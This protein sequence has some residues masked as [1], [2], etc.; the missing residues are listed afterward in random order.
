MSNN[1]VRIKLKLI[2]DI[3]RNLK[4]NNEGKLNHDF[5]W[6]TICLLGEWSL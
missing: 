4:Y 1:K 2:K 3:E 6:P 5:Y